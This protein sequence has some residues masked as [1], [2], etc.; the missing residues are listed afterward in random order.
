M[1]L[2]ERRSLHTGVEHRSCAFQLAGGERRGAGSPV[3]AGWQLNAYFSVTDT[4]YPVEDGLGPPF[5]ETVHRGAFAETLARGPD[6]AFTVN[7]G[8][9]GG[10]PLGRTR[11]GTLQLGEDTRGGYYTVNL[12]PENPDAVALRSAVNRRDCTESSFAFRVIQQEWDP[13]FMKRSIYAVDL[14]RGDVSAVTFGASPATGD[15][16]NATTLR[17]AYDHQ[18]RA[19][20]NADDLKKLKAKGHTFPGTTSYPIDDAE[21]L[22]NAIHAVGRGGAD[23]DSIRKYIIARAKAMGLSSKIPD[24]WNADGSLKSAN[25]AGRYGESRSPLHAPATGSH[26]HSHPA[27]GSQGGDKTHTHTHDGDAS[28]DHSHDAA[29]MIANGDVS[30]Q[31]M[32]QPSAESLGLP[33]YDLE[34]RLAILR[35][36]WPPESPPTEAE[37]YNRALADAAEADRILARRIARTKTRGTR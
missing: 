31:S 27:F 10:L 26:T 36:R 7:H 35:H 29:A 20:Y 2:S 14:D 9:G 3:L 25:A 13:S 19:K 5:Q 37:R 21:D 15:E 33:N 17:A 28:H 11:S 16:G 12:D 30:G 1:N 32:D 34:A 23:H 22:Q 4:P 8:A 6:V 24:N 18:V